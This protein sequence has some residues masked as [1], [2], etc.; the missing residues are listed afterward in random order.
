MEQEMLQ[1]I[2]NTF[3]ELDYEDKLIFKLYV[4]ALAFGDMETV[5]AMEREMQEEKQQKATRC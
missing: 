3:D 4:E 2:M 5:A 1:Q